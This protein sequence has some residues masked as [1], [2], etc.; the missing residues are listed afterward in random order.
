MLSVPLFSIHASVLGDA[1]NAKVILPGVRVRIRHFLGYSAI[2]FKM[3][4]RATSPARRYIW[5]IAC[6]VRAPAFK[7]IRVLRVPRIWCENRCGD[8]WC[9]LGG[10]TWFSRALLC[11]SV[12]V[13]RLFP[14]QSLVIPTVLGI[15][16]SLR[17]S[18]SIMVLGHLE[19][20]RKLNRE[21]AIRTAGKSHPKL[22]AISA[23]CNL[24]LDSASRDV[25]QAA[26]LI[27]HIN[28]RNAHSQDSD[29]VRKRAHSNSGV[30]DVFVILDGV[31]GWVSDN[32]NIIPAS[33][34]R[35]NQ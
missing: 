23:D 1:W 16:P 19:V 17:S 34:S 25:I 32:F 14:I 10:G 35:G 4:I 13:R 6:S 21:V 7:N 31:R 18:L 24:G 30:I 20:A 26:V 12:R 33:P 5:V 22:V 29:H 9:G 3:G 2:P 15:P 28:A 11:P 27:T 8:W